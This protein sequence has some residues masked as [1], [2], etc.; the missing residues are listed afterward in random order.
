MRCVAISI[1]IDCTCNLP[2]YF[3]LPL[4]SVLTIMALLSNVERVQARPSCNTRLDS[5]LRA[6]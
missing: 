6:V 5:L 4:T 3:F 2:A 1:C